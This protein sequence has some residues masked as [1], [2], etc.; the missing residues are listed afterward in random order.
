ME[1]SLILHRY[2]GH[3]FVLN[4]YDHSLGGKIIKDQILGVMWLV[5]LFCFD[6]FKHW[7]GQMGKQKNKKR[8]TEQREERQQEKK[9]RDEDKHSMAFCGS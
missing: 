8:R 7:K 1:E 9:K 4:I 6:S 2:Y 5:P 3:S